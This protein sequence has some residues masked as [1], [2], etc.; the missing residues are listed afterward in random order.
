MIEIKRL[1]LPLKENEIKLFEKLTTRDNYC[2]LHAKN[3]SK[4]NF[5]YLGFAAYEENL[6]IGLILAT[7]VAGL[8]DIKSLFVDEN[9]RHKGT[10]KKLMMAMEQHLKNLNCIVVYMQ[11]ES[12]IKN[13]KELE[14]ILQACEWDEPKPF[15]NRYLY[16]GADFNP[17]W[18]SKNYKLP[19]EFV[20][21][22]WIELTAKD[23]NELR[24]REDEW[25]FPAVIS[26]FLNEKQIEYAN[27]FGIKKGDEIIAW[28]ITHRLNESTIRYSSLYIEPEYQ[29]RG[30]SIFLLIKAMKTQK[31]LITQGHLAKWALFDLNLEQTDDVWQQFITKRLEPYADQRIV[32][33]RTFKV[34][35]NF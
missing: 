17:P 28:I 21:F 4:I 23:K 15:I 10:A 30:F 34:L 22:P 27:S 14:Q 16:K 5:S 29:F 31:E 24:R 13:A 2:Y 25:N 26:P 11:Y 1:E 7:E 9:Y 19:K 20:I 3:P 35:T 32:I 18:I 12:H 8:A 33:N 6:P